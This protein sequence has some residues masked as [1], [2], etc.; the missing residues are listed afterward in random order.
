MAASKYIIAS[1]LSERLSSEASVALPTTAEF[2]KSDL[3]YTQYGRPVS[4]TPRDRYLR[5]LMCILQTYMLAV[6]PVCEQDVVET[7]KL[8]QEY[9]VPFAP[10]SG[11]HCVTTSMRHLTDGILI[12]MRRFK[13]MALDR[14]VCVHCLVFDA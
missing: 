11:H 14:G 9:G 12:D 6:V 4:T 3:R 5:M 8:A 1:A 13:S 10:R 7:V 2:E